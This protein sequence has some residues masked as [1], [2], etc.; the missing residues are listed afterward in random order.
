[1]RVRR[2]AQES[3]NSPSGLW[4]TPDPLDS[5]SFAPCYVPYGEQSLPI[6]S[7]ALEHAAV[8]QTNESN[9]TGSRTDLRAMSQSKQATNHLSKRTQHGS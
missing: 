9:A 1:M 5:P 6:K 7:T 8:S 3:K 4:T 2:Q